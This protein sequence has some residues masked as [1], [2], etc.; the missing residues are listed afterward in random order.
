LYN[1][2]IFSAFILCYE[3]AAVGKKGPGKKGPG[4]KGPVKTVPVKTVLGKN[5]PGKRVRLWLFSFIDKYVP[6]FHVTSD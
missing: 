4:K 3:R 1:C 2:L 5:G 6:R